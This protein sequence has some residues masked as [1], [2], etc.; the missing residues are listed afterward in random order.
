MAG[1]FKFS[2]LLFHTLFK[3]ALASLNSHQKSVEGVA[4][5]EERVVLVDRLQGLVVLKEVIT[6]KASLS[7]LLKILGIIDHQAAKVGAIAPPI[8]LALAVDPRKVTFFFDG[9][10]GSDAS[11]N[12]ITN[13]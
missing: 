8:K 12:G 9:I 13:T 2:L 7:E 1:F 5:G 3:R 11:S 6:D 4:V 10:L